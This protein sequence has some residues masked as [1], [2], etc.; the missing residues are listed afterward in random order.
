AVRELLQVFAG[1]TL[2]FLENTKPAVRSGRRRASA[3]PPVFPSG[4]PAPPG[5]CPREKDARSKRYRASPGPAFLPIGLG[6]N[7]RVVGAT[8][9]SPLPV[10][11]WRR[12]SRY[13]SPSTP[14]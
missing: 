7:S 6:A 9:L 12:V 10:S 14:L 3:V 1:H 2:S 5:A 4:A 8:G 11:L 13:C